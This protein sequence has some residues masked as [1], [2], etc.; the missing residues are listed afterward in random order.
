MN[1]ASKVEDEVHPT[2]ES[3]SK[4]SKQ[5]A[6]GAEEKDLEV[7]P[8]DPLG[9][10][11]KKAAILLKSKF[12]WEAEF[13]KNVVKTKNKMLTGDGLD[14]DD[15]LGIK[16]DDQLQKSNKVTG[17]GGQFFLKMEQI[18]NDFNNSNYVFKHDIDAKRSSNLLTTSTVGW[19][20]KSNM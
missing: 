12:D 13:E 4:V 17:Q 6:D 19:R 16:G 15:S 14:D 11:K 5:D 20:R 3:H 18:A 1:P 7:D 2:E 9:M 8:N 10:A